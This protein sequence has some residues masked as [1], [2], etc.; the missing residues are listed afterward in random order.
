[1]RRAYILLAFGIWF[2][3]LPHLGLPYSW[4]DV[5]FTLT[6]LGL[7]YFSYVLYGESKAK[8]IKTETFDNFRENRE[9]SDE[10]R[11]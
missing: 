9:N 1:M 4:K 5:L 10:G 8:E 6:G 2:A 7:I 11:I 3:V